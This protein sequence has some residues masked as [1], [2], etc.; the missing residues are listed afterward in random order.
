MPIINSAFSFDFINKIFENARK[1][2]FIGIGGVSM[3]ALARYSYLC[4]KE[5][6]GY[7]A[8]RGENCARLEKFSKIKYYSTPDSVCSMDLVIYSN[9]ID[10]NNFEYQNAKKLQ[11]PTLSRANFLEYVSKRSQ[12]QIAIAGTHGKSTTTSVLAKILDFGQK[13]PTVFCGATMR[14]YQSELLWGGGEVCL[15][16]A[17]E[18]M[19]SFLSFHPTIG[20]VLNI[21]YDHPDYFKSYDSLL[22]SFNK[23]F[24]QCKKIVAFIDDDGVKKALSGID[25]SKVVTFSLRDRYA[26][27]FAEE[28][29]DGFVLYKGGVP[30]V[31]AG[32][33]LLGTPFIIDEAC[34]SIIALEY[35]ISP[36]CIAKAIGEA[37][38]VGRRLEF[39]KKLDTSLPV[40]EDYAHHPTEI[41]ATISALKS[42]GYGRIFC[43]FQPH[44]YSRTH[45]LYA[46]FI[47]ALKMADEL[48]ILPTYRAR[49]ENIYG[50]SENDLAKK[51]GGTYIEGLEDVIPHLKTTNCDCAVFM[52]AG[53]ITDFKKLI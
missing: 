11:I 13:K 25:M 6:F 30:L 10:E 48:Y 35:G 45:Y 39:I 23:F 3:S 22:S 24:N 14:D 29:S 28:K 4:G 8:Y 19:D 40:F 2:F 1:I 46:E 41:K 49:E 33:S 32:G 27:Y 50:V 42:R 43:V 47:S 31:S 21:E 20:A 16:E 44:T 26:D 38:G 17:C 9:A 51:S 12:N 37:Q 52:G 36:T 53:S 5:I 18:Y 7:D 34:A 15:Y